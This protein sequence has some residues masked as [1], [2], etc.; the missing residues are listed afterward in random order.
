MKQELAD[1]GVQT[2]LHYPVPL[3]R[4]QAYADLKHREGAFPNSEI[5]ARTVLSLPMYPHLSE[6]QIEFVCDS[7]VESVELVATGG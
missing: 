1:R 7:L 3:H 6:S 5:A 4:Q 2:G